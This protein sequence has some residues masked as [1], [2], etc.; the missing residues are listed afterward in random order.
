MYCRKCGS[1][2]NDNSKFCSKCGTKVVTNFEKAEIAQP[3]IEEKPIEENV[4]SPEESPKMTN[5]VNETKEAT[6]STPVQSSQSSKE[7]IKKQMHKK[8][9]RVTAIGCIIAVMVAVIGIFVG[10][11]IAHPTIKLADYTTVEVEGYNGIATATVTVDWEAIE[12]KYGDKIKYSDKLNDELGNYGLSTSLMS[13]G[14]DPIDYLKSFVSTETDKTSDLSNDD[15][16][17][18]NYSLSEDIEDYFN[19]SVDTTS[20]TYTVSDLEEVETFDAFSNVTMEFSGIDAS[21]EATYNYTGKELSSNNF[22]LDKSYGLS[23]GDE[24]T[25]T[26]TIDDIN[27]FVAKNSKIPQEM[28]KTYTVSGLKNY[29]TSIAEIP[30]A[31]K[32]AMKSQANDVLTAKI[33][34]SNSDSYGSYTYSEAT[35]VGD[36]MINIKTSASTWFS[37]YNKY[38]LIYKLSDGSQDY[39][40]YVIFNNI[41]A[42][43]DGEYD[44][45]LDDYNSEYFSEYNTPD[46]N[47]LD[48][49]KNDVVDSHLDDYT[50]EWT[51]S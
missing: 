3:K 11:K 31:A 17:I 35:Y 10:N 34:S 29:C 18:V 40:T 43:E 16:V 13:L 23:N 9:H 8:N 15:V 25:L 2:L 42:N 39:Y 22:Q 7:D 20:Y 26:I 49:V 36:Y 24:I 21:G 33:A 47:S 50:A 44:V 28:S 41:S 32:D 6:T 1:K 14:G 30:Q 4:V 51:L 38:G 12:T 45:D 27:S 48:A 46:F 5:D 19:C 37:Y